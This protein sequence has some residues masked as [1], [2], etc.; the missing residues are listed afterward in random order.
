MYNGAQSLRCL[1]P[2]QYSGSARVN[3]S[4]EIRFPMVWSKSEATAC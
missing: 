2:M 1:S 4:E 3:M